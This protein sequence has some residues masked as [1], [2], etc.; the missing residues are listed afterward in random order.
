MKNVLI[1]YASRYGGSHYLAERIADKL[2]GMDIVA[3]MLDLR[4]SPAGS[5]PDFD[6]YDGVIVG[7]GIKIGKWASEAEDALEEVQQD[8]TLPYGVFVTCF[9]AHKL[10]EQ[11]AIEKYLIP[12]LLDTDAQ[13]AAISAFGPIIDLSGRQKIGFIDRKIIGSFAKALKKEGFDVRDGEINSLVQDEAID[14]F[15]SSFAD[16]L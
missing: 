5:W 10:G 12:K 2:K 14:A 6:K 1:A 16:A 15:I 13:P 8:G 4:S 7:T 9:D 11:E 3:D